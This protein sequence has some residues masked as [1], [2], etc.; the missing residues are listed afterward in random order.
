MRCLLAQL[1]ALAQRRWGVDFDSPL[2]LPPAN[3][4]DLLANSL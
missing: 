3:H 1:V 2:R 4:M